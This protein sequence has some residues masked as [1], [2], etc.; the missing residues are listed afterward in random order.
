MCNHAGVKERPCRKCSKNLLV[1]LGATDSVS[2]KGSESHSGITPS[3]LAEIS[4]LK[5]CTAYEKIE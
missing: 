5:W 2:T 4:V 3:K 1:A